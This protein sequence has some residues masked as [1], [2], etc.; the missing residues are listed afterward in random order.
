MI[1]Q[2]KESNQLRKTTR[3]STEQHTGWKSDLLQSLISL[4]LSKE[5]VDTAS[6]LLDESDRMHDAGLEAQLKSVYEA[7]GK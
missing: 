3:P 6:I 5:L 2:F 7:F 1:W 4:E